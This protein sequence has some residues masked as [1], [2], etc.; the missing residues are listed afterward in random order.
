MELK[1]KIKEINGKHAVVVTG[2]V[3]SR[4]TYWFEDIDDAVSFRDFIKDDD[5]RSQILTIYCEYQGCF[6]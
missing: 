1:A 3:I 4:H 2:S 6:I 5:N